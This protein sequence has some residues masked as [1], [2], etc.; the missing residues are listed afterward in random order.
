MLTIEPLRRLEEALELAVVRNQCRLTMTQDQREIFPEDQKKWF[1][2][3]YTQQS[4]ISYR[5]W[6]LK[7]MGFVI[8]YFAAK[9]SLE[10]VYITEGIKEDQRGRGRGS[11]LLQGMINQEEFRGQILLADILIRNTASIQLHQKFGF[12]FLKAI[13]ENVTRYHLK[14]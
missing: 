5:V 3:V 4:P 2:M 7:E 1:E 12:R 8:G 9:E 6:L 14:C 13:D 10:G 11:F